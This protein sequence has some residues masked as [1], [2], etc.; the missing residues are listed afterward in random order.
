MTTELSRTLSAHLSAHLSSLDA[1]PSDAATESAQHKLETRLS[2]TRSASVVRRPWFG[3]AAA[4]AT[5]CLVL[6]LVMLPTSQGIAF[7]AVQKH[8]R[9]FTTLS[10]TIEQ[11]SRGINMPTIHVRMNRDGDSRVDTGMATTV[12]NLG[13]RRILTLLHDSHMAMQTPLPLNGSPRAAD[14]LA[15]L[16]AIRQFQGKATRLPNKRI[17]DGRSTTGWALDT[18]GMHITL[19]A[20]SDGFPR[21][22]DINDGQIL[23][24]RIHAV[25]DDP[26]DASVFSTRVPTGYRL[27]RPDAE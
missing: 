20:D 21:A 22:F 16:D 17:I 25:V 9:D 1:T 6:A 23:S 27:M 26:M 4:A 13:E 2:K 7:G 10:L 18:E 12:V 8:L 14:N 3:W 19:W 5:G 15:W 11:R 24:Q